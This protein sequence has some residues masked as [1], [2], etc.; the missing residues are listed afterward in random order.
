MAQVR[1]THHGKF[2]QVFALWPVSSR[3]ITPL[4]LD[5]R[6]GVKLQAVIAGAEVA[7]WLQKG[8]RLDRED[9]GLGFRAA[10]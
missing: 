3:S 5:E 6:C 10:R 2:L 9:A 4:P 8:S 1:T 7:Q